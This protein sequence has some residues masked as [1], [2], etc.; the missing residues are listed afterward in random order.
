MK[1]Y[2]E[3]TDIILGKMNGALITWKE[4][5]HIAYGRKPYP[6]RGRNAAWM[7]WVNSR[8]QILYEVDRIL[9]ATETCRQTSVDYNK[10]FV[11]IPIENV[12]VVQSVKRLRKE[13]K[14]ISKSIKVFENIVNSNDALLADKQRHLMLIGEFKAL[15][16][17]MNQITGDV[18]QLS[19]GVKKK[20]KK[21]LH[22]WGK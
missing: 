3:I 12:G 16:G 5:W 4:L 2:E 6:K 13:V 15:K 8:P 18:K 11:L 22:Y 20:S 1:T 10:G 19:I 21:I 7:L 14:T 17:V 9:T